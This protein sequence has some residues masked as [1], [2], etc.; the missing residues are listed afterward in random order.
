E[1][2]L[3]T[4]VHRLQLDP[5]RRRRGGHAGEAGEEVG[6]EE[7]VDPV[8]ERE[9][10]E[11]R[12]KDTDGH[13]HL[14][15]AWALWRIGA[16]RCVAGPRRGSPRPAAGHSVRV[17]SPRARPIRVLRPMR[18]P[19][20]SGSPPRAVSGVDRMRNARRSIGRVRM[21]SR[22]GTSNDAA[23]LL[24]RLGSEFD[25]VVVG[26]GAGSICAA[27]VAKA[28]G[29]SC[30]ILEKQAKV[31]GA[32]AISGGVLWTPANP[33]MAEEGIPDSY[34]RARRYFDSVVT[35]DGP[36]TAPERRE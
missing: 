18:G 33:L 9:E 36:G 20:R 6:R 15:P 30:V 27:L 34:E 26:S 14:E 10:P 1:A 12:E 21:Q 16:S 25:L 17:A 3:Q 11:D 7:A 22:A 5:A 31:G 32:T 8:R 19:P 13:G 4:A 29:R 28:F 35:Y 24:D 2:R 23:Q